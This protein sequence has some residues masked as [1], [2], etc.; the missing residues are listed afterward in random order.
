MIVGRSKD[1]YGAY[2]DNCDEIYAAGESIEAVKADTEKAIQLIKKNLPEE[3]W[4]AQ[5]KGD[6]EFEWKFGFDF[7]F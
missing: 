4:P 7:T 1:L 2:S 6:Y 3:R 5:I